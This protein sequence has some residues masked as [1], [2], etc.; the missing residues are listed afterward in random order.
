MG[1]KEEGRRGEGTKEGGRDSSPEQMPL[2]AVLWLP[3]LT[4]VDS[5]PLPLTLSHL[6]D[7]CL[8]WA[9]SLEWMWVY[10]SGQTVY[11]KPDVSQ[12]CPHKVSHGRVREDT[13][14]V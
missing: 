11:K 1:R 3:L 12:P 7:T 6:S 5:S 14:S 4:F 13:V 2:L 10:T 8:E 9:P